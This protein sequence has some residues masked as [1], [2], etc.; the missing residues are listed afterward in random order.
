VVLYA[1]GSQVNTV[2]T[3]AATAT[4]TID[5]TAGTV[6]SI[7]PSSGGAG[8]VFPPVVT[9]SGGGGTGAAATATVTGGVVTGFTITNPGNGYTSVPTITVAPPIATAAATATIGRGTGG[10]GT[11]GV[12]SG[13]TIANGGSGYT[14]VPGVALTGGG[15]TGAAATATV[16]NG[17]VTAITVTS[18]GSGY[19]SAPTV[20]I[21]P[22]VGEVT[23][24]A[25]GPFAPGTYQFAAA[26]KDQAGNPSGQSP[27]VS[28]QII[29][30]GTKPNVV[31]DP[32]SES[33]SPGSNIT[34]INGSGGVFLQFDV[35]N[36]VAG[37]TL[38]LLRNGTVVNTITN[39]AGGTVVIGDQGAVLA[40][41][42]YQYTVQQVDNVGN[43]ATSDPVTVTIATSAAAPAA[44]VLQAPSAAG[45]NIT[46]ARNPLFRVA[47]VPA[48]AIVSLFR[49]GVLVDTI[50]TATGG[51][52][53]IG[54]PGPL[55][56]GQYTYTASLIDGAGNQSP[57]SGPV[58]ISI[59]SV[60]GDYIDAGFAQLAVFVRTSPGELDTLV[61]GGITPPGGTAFGSGT[62]DIPFQG[63]LDGDGKTDVILYRPS[64]SQWFAQQSSA[65]FVQY[66][67]GSPG[68]IPV[69]GDFDAVGHDELAVYRPS[70]GQWFVAG[71]ANVFATF[72]GSGD[73]PVA[74]RNYY[75]TGQ[76]VLAVFRPTTGQW[77][78][79]GQ[80][81]PIGFGGA[82]DVPVP[83]FNYYGNGGD[84]LAVFRPSTSQWFVAGQ[85]S[86]ISFG[87]AGDVPV[88][89]DFD[90]VG[91]DEIGVYRPSTGQWFVGGHAGPIATFGGP[92][93]IPLEAPYLYRVAGLSTQGIPAASLYA[94]NFG[95]TAAALSAGSG[96]VTAAAA[97]ATPS[98]LST[99]SGSVA[100][101]Q[102]SAKPHKQVTT[103]A[104][105]AAAPAQTI[106]GTVHDTA[107]AALQG[108]LAHRHKRG[109]SSLLP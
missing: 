79:A 12:V 92:A 35:S 41:G 72:G 39:A 36:V 69:V 26:Q 78:V 102:V 108:T 43:T 95:A 105:A 57:L 66:N 82:G 62:L 33:G 88:A 103:S 58:T 56:G 13:I 64:T 87:G 91:H 8:Y 97:T 80:A 24:A 18:P 107:L 29:T 3:A 53:A 47:G 6:T 17:V 49:N 27:P 60:K 1:N 28:I 46:S 54:D 15:G 96:T 2:T 9:I 22:P 30:T 32:A 14:S 55:S 106:S 34:K 74:L 71:H 73:I 77:F 48:S 101:P 38:N 20:T 44:P 94:F 90:A 51:T 25:P 21:A 81:N 83:L 70:T 93:D 10:A 86:G 45:A 19:T 85:G 98:A 52:V 16:V 4:A 68:D 89:A 109:H 104:V 5:N 63:D 59:V 31:L 50:T 100:A 65:G 84:V 75:G 99:A 67:F 76:D 61:A 37:A 42:A 40:D 23:I 7:T 11:G